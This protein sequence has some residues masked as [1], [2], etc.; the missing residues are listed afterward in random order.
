MSVLAKFLNPKSISDVAI[1]LNATLDYEKKSGKKLYTDDIK[2]TIQFIKPQLILGSNRVDILGDKLSINENYGLIG[3]RIA[4]YGTK[5]AV[6]T[7]QT[8]FYSPW[9]LWGFR[10]N[11][12]FNY[13]VAMLGN[14]KRGILESKA[15][16]KIG[17]GLIIS[18]D[19]LVFS[20]F[21]ISLCYFPSIPGN[22]YN[23]FKT[24]SFETSDFGFQDFELA[25]PRTVIYK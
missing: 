10:L 22:G 4:E 9:D 15:Y 12:Y 17:I 2:E 6:V 24:N 23:I 1:N 16:S 19:Y 3:F 11:P 25:K 8:Q 7:M 20:S 13:S 21:Q 18:N 14:A 5:K